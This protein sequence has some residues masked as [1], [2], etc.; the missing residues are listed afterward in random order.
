MRAL[1]SLVT[2]QNP[3]SD[4]ELHCAAFDFYDH[5]T[6]ID[7]T[8][9]GAHPRL[10]PL[11]EALA[12]DLN[13]IAS[14]S[15]ELLRWVRPTSLAKSESVVMVSALA[16]AYIVN[17][18]SAAD[19]VGS[20]AAYCTATKPGQA[21]NTSLNDL[22]Q[23]VKKN[24]SR[25]RPEVFGFLQSDWSW[26]YEMRT[27]RDL[28]VHEGLHANI[29]T[30]RK[31]YSLWVYSPKRGWITRKPLFP[32]LA[33]WTTCLIERADQ[34]GKIVAEY[35]CLPP[36]RVGSRV[37]EGVFVPQLKNFLKVAHKYGAPEPS[38]L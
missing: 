34:C 13:N 36:E 28:L 14:L 19:V 27:M 37:L 5:W 3:S 35:V 16:E 24:P 17:L 6:E 20:M 7:P 18:R 9:S 2:K 4:A 32:I 29:A 30:N 11:C 12:F 8:V 38:H 23:W 10:P 26:F 33:R 21:P 22:L 1:G 15:S 31:Q 25:V